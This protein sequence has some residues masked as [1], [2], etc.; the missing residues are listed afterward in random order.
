MDNNM[1]TQ[2]FC[3]N[4]G[5]KINSDA[6]FCINCGAKVQQE[7]EEPKKQFCTNCGKELQ[8]GQHFCIVCGQK[9]AEEAPK[10]QELPIPNPPKKSSKLWIILLA[11]GVT[12]ILV[13]IL[14]FF[15]I[16]EMQKQELHDQLAYTDWY[17]YDGTLKKTLYFGDSIIEYDAHFTYIGKQNIATYNYE[18]IDGDTIAIDGEEIDVEI[19]GD[20]VTFSPSFINSDSYS[21]WVKD[22]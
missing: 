11:A 7:V 2:T 22:W 15:G 12:T 3:T 14:A 17:T 1:E 9:V 8:E 16:K 13:F 4:C 20:S 5:S 21:L 18:V 10:M 19:D 6:A